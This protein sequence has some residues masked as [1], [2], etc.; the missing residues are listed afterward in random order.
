MREALVDADYLAPG[1]VMIYALID[2]RFPEDYRYVGQTRRPRLRLWEHVNDSKRE[3][4]KRANWVKSVIA[5]G[6]EVLMRDLVVV[7]ECEA[8]RAEAAWMGMLLED[9]HRLKNGTTRTDIKVLDERGR[10]RLSAANKRAW[11]DPPRRA[12][13]ISSLTA[14]EVIAKNRAAQLALWA[15]A[16][17]RERMLAAMFSAEARAAKKETMA[18][19]EYRRGQ[20]E[21]SR[22]AWAAPELRAKRIESLSAAARRPETRQKISEKRKEYLAI[23]GVLQKISA[24]SAER[25]RTPEGREEARARAN[26]SW[27]NPEERAR[28]IASMK[29]AG[30]K[31]RGVPRA[32]NVG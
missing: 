32:R 10:A 30:E 18:T 29:A 27:A 9:G 7:P 1:E 22:A 24:A 19:D 21:I 12:A 15:D 2:S 6:G 14:P 16:G 13:W 8:Y 23:P 11:A 4:N 20:G 5:S 25:T 3:R 26:R 31:R 28:R 17:H